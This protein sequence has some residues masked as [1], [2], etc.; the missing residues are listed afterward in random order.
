MSR[1]LIRLEINF[2]WIKNTYKN[3]NNTIRLIEIMQKENCRDNS[4]ENIDWFEYKEK[5]YFDR[6]RISIK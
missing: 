3:K 5:E 2:D 1:E 6:A 4:N